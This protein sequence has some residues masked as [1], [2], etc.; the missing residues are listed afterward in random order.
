MDTKANESTLLIIKIGKKKLNVSHISQRPQSRKSIQRVER[1][2][3]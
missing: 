1:K 2:L 3:R